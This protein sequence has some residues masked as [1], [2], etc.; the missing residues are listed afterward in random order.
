MGLTPELLLAEFNHWA[1]T[2]YRG[3]RYVQMIA[4]RM[5]ERPDVRLDEHMKAIFR[6]L[7]STWWK[8]GN[9]SPSLI[10]AN[11]VAFERAL[12]LAESSHSE[13]ELEQRHLEA[14]LL[15]EEGVSDAA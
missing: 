14:P 10:F 8:G 15:L 9:P 4:D 12:N 13:W 11:P 6:T 5:R 2:S 3:S 7:K 1:G